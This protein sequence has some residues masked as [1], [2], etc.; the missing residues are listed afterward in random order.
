MESHY[1]AQLQDEVAGSKS[2]KYS[3]HDRVAHIML[4]RPARMNAINIPMPGELVRAVEMANLDDSVK[5]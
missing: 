5:V 2:L 4:N 1:V 3:V